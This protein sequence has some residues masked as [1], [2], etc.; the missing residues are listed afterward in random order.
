[1]S[2]VNSSGRTTTFT[3][4]RSLPRVPLP[5]LEES[6]ERFLEWCGPLLTADEF[7]TTEAAVESFLLPDSPAHRLQGALEQYNASDGVHSWLDAFWADRYLGRR[8]PIALNANYFILFKPSSD[9]QIARATSLVAGIVNYK[10]LLDAGRIPPAVERGQPLSMEQNK[11]LFSTTRIPGTVRDTLRSPYSPNWPG[12]TQERHVVVFFRGNLFRMDVIGSDGRPFAPS[13]LAAGLRAGMAACADRAVPGTSVGHLTSKARA[14]WAANRRALL[15]HHPR[16]VEMLDAIERALF[17]LSL[18]EDTPGDAQTACAQLLHGDSGNRWFDKSLSLIV[19]E[20]G[21]AGLN[22]EHSALDGAT[23]VNFVDAT[24]D[25]AGHD[26]L[27]GP[28]PKSHGMPAWEAIEFVLDPDLRTQVSA[29]ADSFTALAGA[30]ATIA[31]SFDDFGA[32]RAKQLKISPDAFVQMAYQLAHKRSRGFL[33]ATYESIA[34]RQYRHGRTE[35]MRVVTPEMVDFVSAMLDPNGD[36]KTRRVALHAAAERHVERVKE[37]RAGHA[38]EQHLWELQLIQRRMGAEPLALFNTP[39]WLKMRDDR[40]STS[41]TLASTNIEYSGFG[42]T[43]TQCIGVSYMMLPDMLK[44]HLSAPRPI[45]D[46]MFRFAHQLREVIT[47][48]QT[49]LSVEQPTD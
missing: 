21:A 34:T 29:A 37:C 24:F 23:I 6:C 12:P 9:G 47:E 41:S 30:T 40:L 33:G 42:P 17:C 38:P 46:E 3:S 16:N 8:D 15:D 11:F 1:M 25:H 18:E 26:P 14:D 22:V 5:T 32:N 43:G 2:V 31:V 48:L 39:G 36:N 27:G 7:A 4:E 28:V 20:D 35:A 44:L 19:F 45:A 10:L 13:E 49:V